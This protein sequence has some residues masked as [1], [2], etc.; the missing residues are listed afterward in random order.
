[1]TDARKSGSTTPWSRDELPE[2]G[3]PEVS[4]ISQQLREV[5]AL[6]RAFERRLGSVLTVNQ[7]D[8]TAMEHLIQDGPL[9]PSELATR[10]KVS[11]AASTLVVDR[12]VALGH[13][14]RHPHERDRRKIVVVP[15]R[16]SVDRT[17]QELLP[18]ILGVAAIVEE[19]PEADREVVSTFLDRV[20]D[21]Y[22]TAAS[23]P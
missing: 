5:D 16:A 12:L 20:A 14:E 3:M 1:M 2:S 13:A 17:V 8:L 9:T 4:P 10:L 19:M 11:T 7:T 18:V 22:R 6:S 23:A 21:V 15:A